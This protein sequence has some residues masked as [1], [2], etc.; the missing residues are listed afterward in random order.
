MKKFLALALCALMMLSVLTACGGNGGSASSNKGSASASTPGS[1]SGSQSGSSFSGRRPSF[2]T[3]PMSKQREWGVAE[4][5]L[6][7]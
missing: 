6:S 1:V 7:R 5:S 3:W 2:Q 4:T